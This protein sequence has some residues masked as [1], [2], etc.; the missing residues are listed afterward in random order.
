MKKLLALSIIFLLLIGLCGCNRFQ[1]TPETYAAFAAYEEAVRQTIAQ[2]AGEI[3]VVTKNQDTVVE[4]TESL[5]VIEYSFR[6][7]DQNRVSFERNDF[8]ND[9]MVAS[10]Y[11]DGKAAYQMDLS[12][13]KWIDVTNVSGDMLDHDKNIFSNLSLF[14]IDHN[15]RYSKRFYESVT[16]EEAEG[17]KIITVVIKNSELDQMFSMTDEKGIR[18]EM[19][20]QTRKYYIDEEGIIS[21]IIIDTAQNITYKGN[22][23]I[24]TNLI[25]VTLDY[26]V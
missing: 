24:L 20:S 3:T 18:R 23:G 9:E 13:D 7:D 22:S 26:E 16:M 8:T 6:V 4:K 10:Y 14:R 15:F 11:G 2:K 19:A 1:D 5:G 21:K 12:T 25:T 17:E